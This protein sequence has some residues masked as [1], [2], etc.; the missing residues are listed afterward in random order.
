MDNLCWVVQGTVPWHFCIC[1][2]SWTLNTYELSTGSWNMRA[3]CLDILSID[4]IWKPKTIWSIILINSNLW[5]EWFLQTGVVF[6][7]FQVGGDL[8][9][10]ENSNRYCRE[11]KWKLLKNTKSL[12]SKVYFFPCGIMNKCLENIFFQIFR[13]STI[14]FNL[15]RKLFLLKQ[16]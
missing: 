2:T 6:C 1:H 15:F 9:L 8:N 3:I 12:K 7:L 4:T 16:N 13:I 10:C 11:L 14:L 5:V